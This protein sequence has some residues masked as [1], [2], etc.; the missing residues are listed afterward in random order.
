MEPER[1]TMPIFIKFKPTA[2]KH[3]LNEEDIKWAFLHPRYDGPIEDGE[4]RYIRIGFDPNGNLL[5]ILYNEI[6][7]HTASVF[8]AMKC[9]KIFFHLLNHRRNQ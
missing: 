9:R 2:F 5:E 8:H 4:N 3:G 1:W 6:D 7:E